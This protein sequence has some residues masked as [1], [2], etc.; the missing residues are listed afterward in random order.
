MIAVKAR[1]INHSANSE[2][3]REQAG[4]ILKRVDSFAPARSASGSPI[5]VAPLPAGSVQ[6]VND[7]TSAWLIPFSFGGVECVRFQ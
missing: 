7:D 1:L 2:I 6:R 5:Y 4:P 3:V